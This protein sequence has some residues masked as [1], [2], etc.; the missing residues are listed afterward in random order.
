MK[1]EDVKKREQ[2][3][4]MKRWRLGSIAIPLIYSLIMLVFALTNPYEFANFRILICVL[5]ICVLGFVRFR[6]K[7]K[8]IEKELLDNGGLTPK[9][10]KTY[11]EIFNKVWTKWSVIWAFAIAIIII[12]TL[13]PRQKASSNNHKNDSDYSKGDYYE[14]YD[15][16]YDGKINQNE[17]E[18]ALGD[19]MDKIMK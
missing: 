5:I 15:Y 14:D 16:D 1:N 7:A 8:K 19:Y 2:F 6:K 12:S 13:M 3:Y 18:D 17:W 4:K 11:T 9:E 10:E